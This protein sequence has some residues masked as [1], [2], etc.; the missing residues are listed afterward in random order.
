MTYPYAARVRNEA[1]RRSIQFD[2]DLSGSP[3]MVVGDAKKIRTVVANLTANAGMSYH[4]HPIL[5]DLLSIYSQIYNGGEGYCV[6][7]QVRG[8]TGTSG[9]E[10]SCCRNYRW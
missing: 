6:M 10:G 9:R 3:K 5:L 7:S 1:V 2:L 8:A 4:H